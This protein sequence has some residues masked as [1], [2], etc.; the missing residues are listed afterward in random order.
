VEK[1]ACIS[2]NLNVYCLQALAIGLYPRSED[3]SPHSPSYI[4]NIRFNI[5]LPSM[6]ESSKQSHSTPEPEW[7]SLPTRP[8]LSSLIIFGLNHYNPIQIMLNHSKLP[9]EVPQGPLKA[10]SFKFLEFVS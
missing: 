4:F 3:A 8:M 7:I 6:P 2:W 10:I 1:T 5:N 9:S